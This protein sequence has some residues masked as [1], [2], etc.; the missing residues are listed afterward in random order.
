MIK[1]YISLSFFAL[2]LSFSAAVPA[3]AR[4]EVRDFERL[5]LLQRATGQPTSENS[6]ETRVNALMDV[7][8]N[9]TPAYQSQAAEDA[10][11]AETAQKKAAEAAALDAK[12][13]E[14]SLAQSQ[15]SPEQTQTGRL[16]VYPDD[17]RDKNLHVDA[18]EETFQKMREEEAEKKKQYEVLKNAEEDKS[19]LLNKTID[20][21]TLAPSLANNPF[22]FPGAPGAAKGRQ[23]FEN[24]KPVL[25][26][27]LIQNG[28][29]Q[30]QVQR[31]LADAS[32]AEE[33]VLLLMDEGKTYGE[34][35]DLTRLE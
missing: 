16:P 12:Y 26:S 8:T 22:Y 28:F 21:K 2:I 3:Q 32:T 6:F 33:L 7:T 10:K 34:A 18:S 27:R 13:R 5:R 20:D 14:R 35:A 23:D 29:T 1:K 11:I 31:M 24:S 19:A 15:P 30:F 17:T 25:M 4:D 9:V